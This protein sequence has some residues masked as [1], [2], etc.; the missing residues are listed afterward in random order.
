MSV[1]A[2]AAER[3]RFPDCAT[4][5]LPHDP[6][7]ACNPL[8]VK[9]VASGHWKPHRPTSVRPGR[10]WSLEVE[11]D[12]LCTYCNPKCTHDRCAFTVAN[13]DGCIAY[14]KETKEAHRRAAEAIEL[15]PKK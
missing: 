1:D 2:T 14:T 10:I 6:A 11:A 9:Y 13:C 3:I 15:T 8:V 5:R 7:Q 12:P 4:C